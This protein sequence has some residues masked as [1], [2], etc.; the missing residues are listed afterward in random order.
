MLLEKPL[1]YF[2]YGATSGEPGQYSFR[3]SRLLAPSSSAAWM[4]AL[5]A[6]VTDRLSYREEVITI[7]PGIVAYR[8]NNALHAVF[9]DGHVEAVG[10]EEVGKRW[11]KTEWRFNRYFTAD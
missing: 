10:R 1:P 2:S 6:I 3:I 4:D 9:F 5:S 11:N 7:V 8:H